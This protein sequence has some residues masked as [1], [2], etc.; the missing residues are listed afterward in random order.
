MDQRPDTAALIQREGYRW[1]KMD[2]PTAIHVD[3]AAEV[4][5]EAER[6][7]QRCPSVIWAQ[8][9]KI[10]A[11]QVLG[12]HDEAQAMAQQEPPMPPGLRGRTLWASQRTRILERYQLYSEAVRSRA[13]RASTIAPPAILP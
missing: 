2:E 9:A 4:L 1:V 10:L 8:E 12:R 13:D 7:L 11:L 5:A 3:H 6:T